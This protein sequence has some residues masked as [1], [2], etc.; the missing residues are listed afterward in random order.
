MKL[1]ASVALICLDEVV[2]KRMKL[3][4]LWSRSK[5]FPY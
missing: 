3:F 5:R 2:A 4:N 1:N